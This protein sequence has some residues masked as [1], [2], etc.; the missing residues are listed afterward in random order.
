MG[1]NKN[2]FDFN[3]TEFILYIWSKRK[4]L[5]VVSIFAAVFSGIISLFIPPKY[6]A[7]VVM[8]P[9]STSSVAKSMI[10]AQNDILKFGAEQEG[11][12]LMQVLQSDEIFFAINKKINLIR[13]YGIDTTQKLWR[14]KLSSKYYENLSVRRTEFL[15]VIVEVSD[16][17][18]DTC[19]LI[20]NEIANQVDTVMTKIYRERALKTL[21]VVEKEY[22][23]LSLHVKKLEDSLQMLASVGVFEFRAQAK[24]YNEAYAKAI[25]NGKTS[26]LKT[27]EGKLKKLEYYG[28]ADLVIGDQ[29]SLEEGRL[30]DLKGKYMYAKIDAEQNI[31]H[32]FILDKAQKPEKKA[33]PKRTLIVISSVIATFF[34][35]LLLLMFKDNF[36]TARKD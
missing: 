3:S 13:H 25:A 22:N 28:V 27:L 35:T 20:A 34:F 6:K 36:V 30:S 2:K 4:T 15:S 18:K 24:A 16:K 26:G 11:E 19:A 33:S 10:N 29:I 9:V 7:S 14:T 21:A 8:F 23:D 12:H 17:S 31:P 5:I 1:K 32:K